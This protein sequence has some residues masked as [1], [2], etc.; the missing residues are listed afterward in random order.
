MKH[1]RVAVLIALTLFVASTLPALARPDL[2]VERTV[3]ESTVVLPF[4]SVFVDATGVP[5]IGEVLLEQTA[6]E[7]R[8]TLCNFVSRD[9]VRDILRDD[10]LR[11]DR[12]GAV[13]SEDDPSHVW[14]VEEFNRLVLA[15]GDLYK[16]PN[17]GRYLTEEGHVG[18]VEIVTFEVNGETMSIALSEN[19][20]L[21]NGRVLFI[22]VYADDNST[23]DFDFVQ[24]TGERWARMI[25]SANHPYAF[26][27]TRQ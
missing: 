14:T 19:V 8:T 13:Q 11:V 27:L 10:L 16:S 26:D 5:V 20:I 2:T 17:G 18:F 4:P 9:A 23:E 7:G 24:A 3:G 22:Y 15:L 21:V 1:F 6:V 25:L 12:Y